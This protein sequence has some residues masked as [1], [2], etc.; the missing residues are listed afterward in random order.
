MAAAAGPQAICAKPQPAGAKRP[1]PA[2]TAQG[3]CSARKLAAAVNSP[4]LSATE[5]TRLR[6]QV[7]LMKRAGALCTT[8]A[9]TPTRPAPAKPSSSR[10]SMAAYRSA[11]NDAR[12]PE[13]VKQKIR[14]Y[15]DLLKHQHLTQP[16]C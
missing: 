11:L 7:R 5:R 14:A 12:V 15:L 3:A 16:Y 2:A 10:C 1:H 9:Q 8:G 13:T 6:E 4:A